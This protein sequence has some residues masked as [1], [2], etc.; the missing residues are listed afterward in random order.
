[1][2]HKF[3]YIFVPEE[4]T[5]DIRVGDFLRSMVAPHTIL[6]KILKWTKGI[7]I[8]K[9]STTI[10]LNERH[11]MPRGRDKFNKPHRPGG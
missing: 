10:H 8:R 2:S 1:V 5:M 11:T 3:T 6:G 7:S 4:K 9:G